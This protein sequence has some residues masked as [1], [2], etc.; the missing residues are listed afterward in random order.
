MTISRLLCVSLFLLYLVSAP[1]DKMA[2]AA[3]FRILILGDSLTSG[4]GLQ[5]GQDYP[6]VL[7]RIMKQFDYPV[8]IINGGVSG[9]TMYAGSERL[10]FHLEDK[11]HL[12]LIALGGNDALRNVPI[13]ITRNAFD[14]ILKTLQQR[15]IPTAIMGMKAPRNM[16]REYIAQFDSLFPAMAKKYK[17]PIYPFFLEGVAMVPKYNL[18]DGVHPNAAGIYKMA[19]KT[20]PFIMNLVYHVTQSLN[21]NQKNKNTETPVIGKQPA[22]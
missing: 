1:F 22:K 13:K 2:Y 4:Y 7:E 5:K 16:G 21:K 6:A 12:V 11:P 10:E 8:K 19:E 20:A 17:L 9:D 3:E 14:R 15:R 18:S